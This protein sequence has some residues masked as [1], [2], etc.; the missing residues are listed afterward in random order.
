MDRGPEGYAGPAPCPAPRG[1]L[2]ALPADKAAAVSWRCSDAERTQPGSQIPSQEVSHQTR[3]L[4]AQSQ[5]SP[6]WGRS[7]AYERGA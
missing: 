6:S 2:W 1:P 4:P 3:G 7:S 5:P